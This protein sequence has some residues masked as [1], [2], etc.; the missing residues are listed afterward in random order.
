MYSRLPL[1][2]HNF[3]E[4]LHTSHES[5]SLNVCQLNVPAQLLCPT[6]VPGPSQLS[7]LTE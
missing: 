4:R 7:K 1:V 3:L 2:I 6:V 5:V